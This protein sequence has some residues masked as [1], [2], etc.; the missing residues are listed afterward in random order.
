MHGSEDDMSFL[1][2]EHSEDIFFSIE[3]GHEV[4]IQKQGGSELEKAEEKK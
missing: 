3:K 1:F 4:E 2:R